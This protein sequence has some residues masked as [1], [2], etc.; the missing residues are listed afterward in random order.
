MFL[1]YLGVY[2]VIKGAVFFEELF[3][4]VEVDGGEDAFE[5]AFPFELGFGLFYYL[6][7]FFRELFLT[8]IDISNI[9]L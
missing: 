9:S 2:E 7:F 4:V 5:G 1:H 3:V 8:V 6:L